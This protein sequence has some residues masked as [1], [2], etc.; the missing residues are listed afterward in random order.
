MAV[1]IHSMT[2]NHI[3]CIASWIRISELLIK[4]LERLALFQY[5][6]YQDSINF[7]LERNINYINTNITA[8]QTSNT[9]KRLV[10]AKSGININIFFAAEKVQYHIW[11][12]RHKL[13]NFKVQTTQFTTH[14]LELK[15]NIKWATYRWHETAKNQKFLSN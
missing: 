5:D 15:K 10:E 6:V 12:I 4:P 1:E 14:Y 9:C 11:F 13:R 8:F 7:R 3:Y 2:A